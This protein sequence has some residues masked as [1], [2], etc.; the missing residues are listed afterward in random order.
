MA[1]SW[2]LARVPAGLGPATTLQGPGPL[3]LG[4]KVSNNIV[5][6]GPNVSN[7]HARLVR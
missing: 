4:R 1:P 6:R 7:R 2:R 5:C 3:T